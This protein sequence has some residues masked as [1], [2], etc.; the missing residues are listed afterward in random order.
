MPCTY[1]VTGAALHMLACLRA[2]LR[3]MVHGW[4]RQGR[5][6]QGRHLAGVQGRAVA[7]WRRGAAWGCQG[8]A[9]AAE[10]ATQLLACLF[11]WEQ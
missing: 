10:V 3:G 5:Q 11:V 8:A 1:A 2:C 7:G 4:A 6:A 9:A